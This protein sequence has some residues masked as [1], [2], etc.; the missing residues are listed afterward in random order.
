MGSLMNSLTILPRLGVLGGMGPLASVDFMRK[1]IRATPANSDQEHLPVI[2]YSVPQIPD[3]SDAIQKGSDEPWPYLLDGLRTLEGAGAGAIAIPCN[4]AHVWHARLASR[5]TATVLHMVRAA[6][7]RI[8][9]AYPAGC[10]I[11][12]LATT[13]TLASR[14]YHCDLETCGV[15][16]VEPDGAIQS[17]FVM[18]GIR[19]VKANDLQLGSALLYESAVH[20]LSLGVDMLL[21]AC[22][23]IPL[24]L[25][26]LSFSVP[27][28]DPTDALAYA[29][30]RWWRHACDESLLTTKP[31]QAHDGGRDSPA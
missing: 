28:L 23:E 11:G 22:T 17:Q 29:C 19:A 7:D 3:R 27:V 6:R 15:T 13:A 24:A 26:D 31:V 8:L 18:A 14:I 2:V 25:A 5:S 16:L 9:L 10:R 12:I 4:S 20:L 30:V 1:L 21:L